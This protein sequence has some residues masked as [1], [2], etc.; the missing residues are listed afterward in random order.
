VKLRTLE[1]RESEQTLKESRSWSAPVRVW[2]RNDEWRSEDGM[3]EGSHDGE[4]RLRPEYV[5]DESLYNSDWTV[6]A[7][8]LDPLCIEYNDLN[9]AAGRYKPFNVTVEQLDSP[10][11]I[12]E[13]LKGLESQMQQGLDRLLAM[14]EGVQ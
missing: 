10:K 6:K 7:E 3:L 8:Y 11:L 4:G 2:R 14:V 1:V 13:Q 9:L 5:A 12:I